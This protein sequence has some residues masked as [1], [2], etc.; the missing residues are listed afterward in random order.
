MKHK[1]GVYLCS[2]NYQE[3]LLWS[4]RSLENQTR[5]PDVVLFIDDC[6]TDK[7]IEVFNKELIRSE[8]DYTISIHKD[9]IGAVATMN[10]A[11][12]I[13][14][15]KGCDYICGLSADDLF[16]KDYLK[17][18]EKM[19]SKAPKNVGYVYTWVKRIGDELS[20]DRHEEFNGDN[21]MRYNFVHGSALIKATAWRAVGGLQPLKVCE[22]WD[23]FKRM[24]RLG[25][26]GR[27]IPKPLLMWRKHNKG[28]RTNGT[29]GK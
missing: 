1:L 23:L 25:I 20:I 18:T 17:E 3:F 7:S 16:D 29:R 21:L 2:Y 22:D 10:E 8:L 19:L 4:M 14:I 26:I 11:V 24:A 12:E 28:C 27:V 6:S 13:L 9:N 15:S 5:K